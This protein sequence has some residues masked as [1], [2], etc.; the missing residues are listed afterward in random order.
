MMGS[1]IKLELAQ[2]ECGHKQTVGQQLAKW[3]RLH[4]LDD[5]RLSQREHD[6]ATKAPGQPVASELAVHKLMLS[7]PSCKKCLQTRGERHKWDKK[8]KAMRRCSAKKRMNLC[9]ACRP[10]VLAV[11]LG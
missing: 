6:A 8:G 3:A 4:D 7:R 1:R 2:V 10:N 5:Q 11:R 9:T